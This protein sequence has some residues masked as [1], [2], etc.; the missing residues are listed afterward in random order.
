M[1]ALPAVVAALSGLLLTAC[2]TPPAGG[3]LVPF[4][5]PAHFAEDEYESLGIRFARAPR[6]AQLTVD[7]ERRPVLLT[8]PEGWTW[9]GRVPDGA[10][11]RLGVQ[12]LPREGGAP[13]GFTARVALRAEGERRVLDAGEAPAAG[14]ARRVDLGADLAGYGGRVVTLEVAAEVTPAPAAEEDQRVVAWGPVSLRGAPAGRQGPPSV[15]LVVIDTLRADRVGA[16][17][18]PRDTTPHVDRL[19]AGKGALF[20]NAYAQA[21]WTLP[22]ALSYLTGR[23]P[24]ELFQPADEAPAIPASVPTLAERLRRAGYRTGAFVANPTLHAGAGFD[25]GFETWWTPPAEVASLTLPGAA[26]NRRALPW[27]E[28]HRGTPS[29]LYV[30]YLDPHDPYTSPA[31]D[32]GRTPFDPDYEGPVTGDQVHGVYLGRVEVDAAGREHLSALYDSE[33]AYVDEMIGGLLA[34]LEP[35][36]ADTLVVLTADHGEEL[37]D[38]GGWKHG[39]TLYNEQIRVPFVFRW[40]GRIP[41]RRRLAGSVRLVDL[42]PTVLSAAG[43]ELEGDLDGVDLLPILLG[44]ETLPRRAALAEHLSFGPL[45]AAAVLDDWKLVLFNETAPFHPTDP[46]QVATWPR[47]RER[48]SRVEL[49]DLAG[50]PGETVNLAGARPERVEQLAPLIHAQ[51]DRELPGL[52]VLLA[53]VPRGRRVT[54]RVVFAEAPA[55]W[56]P[57][58]LTAG[59]SAHLEGAVLTFDLRSDLLQKGVRVVGETGALES[60]E[61]A[62]DGMPVP[63]RRIL[64]GRGDPY[65][66]GRVPP[67]RFTTAEWPFRLSAPGSPVLRLWRHP[68]DEA[69]EGEEEP[70]RDAVDEE[71]RRRLEALGY[72]G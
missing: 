53:D 8:T 70:G 59:D 30:H 62:V 14:P 39:H 44:I 43:V 3:F 58:F 66:G 18:S 13:Q 12:A 34:A 64:L 40:D 63:H 35:D 45:R 69:R 68:V 55:G 5:E 9:R 10:A 57:Y 19:L 21:P 72:L 51:L 22:S 47:D 36:L 50:D 20:E 1:R 11:L 67:G 61:V 4:G 54:G 15:V 26:L 60:V 25:R 24:G 37:G 46:V 2:P 23:H 17:G 31:L 71:T 6:Q 33:V 49:Y 27:V 52:K 56:W 65:R 16:Y 42:V 29:F 41:A 7:G 28:A 38:H 32:G 48:L